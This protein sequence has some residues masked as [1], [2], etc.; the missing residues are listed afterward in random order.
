[1]GCGAPQVTPISTYRFASVT[2]SGPA[3]LRVALRGKPAEKVVLLY[4]VGNLFSCKSS[5]ATIG[6]DGAAIVM[7]G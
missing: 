1:V 4:V 3:G 5:V 6:A 2:A 7:L